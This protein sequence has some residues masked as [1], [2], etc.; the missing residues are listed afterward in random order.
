MQNAIA[1]SLA[2]G[3]DRTAA[4][5]AS[6]VLYVLFGIVFLIVLPIIA[7]VYV[8]IKYCFSKDTK[9]EKYKCQKGTFR[10]VSIVF[11]TIGTIMYY[12]GDNADSIVGEELECSDECVR[13]NK[14]AQSVMLLIST[15]LFFITPEILQRFPY[16]GYDSYTR[17]HHVIFD[18]SA[19]IIQL[20]SLYASANIIIDTDQS[21][22]EDD[23]NVRIA[24]IVLTLF[25]G[26]LYFI[27]YYVY[28]IGTVDE[29][30][31]ASRQN[32]GE[33]WSWLLTLT[34]AIFGLLSSVFYVLADNTQPLGCAFGCD[35]M[36]IDNA[37]AV[38]G[39]DVIQCDVLGLSVA[40]LIF[41]LLSCACYFFTFLLALSAQYYNIR[42]LTI[43]KD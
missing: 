37:T 12:Y 43:S 26:L 14:F 20:N 3:G 22:S 21:C 13:N 42:N 7:L 33:L 28:M 32:F 40:S 29:P 11:L 24:S 27:F 25:I 23:H 1:I 8:I 36:N 10:I 34:V 18:V 30:K 4:K 19:V 31:H 5:R 2:K 39:T 6:V 9:Q 15:L 35:A 38:I 16:M 41:I 17:W